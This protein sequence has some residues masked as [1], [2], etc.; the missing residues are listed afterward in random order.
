MLPT[1]AEAEGGV[2]ELVTIVGVI[3]IK[4]NRNRVTTSTF[5]LLFIS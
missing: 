1:Y 2:C 4:N 3:S 5:F